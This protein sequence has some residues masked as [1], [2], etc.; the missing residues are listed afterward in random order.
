M[1]KL[2]Q[3][4]NNGQMALYPDP[5][6]DRSSKRNDLPEWRGT[7]IGIDISTQPTDTFTR[8]LSDIRDVYSRD[9][10]QNKESI[11]KKPNFI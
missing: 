3:T 2:L 7:V 1:Y 5:S 9:L 8:L 11:Y 10:K 6:L 4:K